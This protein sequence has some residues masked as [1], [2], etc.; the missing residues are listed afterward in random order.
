MLITDPFDA[1]IWI[2]VFFCAVAFI[3]GGITYKLEDEQ[4]DEPNTEYKN[5]LR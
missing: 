5:R 2:F 3:Y 4:I 1:V